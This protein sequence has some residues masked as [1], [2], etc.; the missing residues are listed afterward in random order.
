MEEIS[1]I[2]APRVSVVISGDKRE[3]ASEGGAGEAWLNQDISRFRLLCRCCFYLLDKE[4][5]SV[6]LGNWLL[7][8]TVSHCS[9][10]LFI[11]F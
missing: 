11:R 8:F 5:G 9:L 7:T 6:L 3:E 10:T 4:L 2:N 1:L